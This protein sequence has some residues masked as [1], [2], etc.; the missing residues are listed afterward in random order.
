MYELVLALCLRAPPW[1]AV[2][3]YCQ[4]IPLV[5]AR[6]PVHLAFQTASGAN[7]PFREFIGQPIILYMKKTLTASA[8]AITT[9]ITLQAQDL[10][11]SPDRSASEQT[12][13]KS[14]ICR[15][16]AILCV[17]FLVIAT[18]TGCKSTANGAGKDI[19]KMGEKIQD[20]TD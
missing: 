14:N 7:T 4:K 18:A 15:F 8:L 2:S 12:I 16:V 19:Q 17:S 13:M 6:D 10:K 3:R 20:K 1:P 11:T 5:P 9:G